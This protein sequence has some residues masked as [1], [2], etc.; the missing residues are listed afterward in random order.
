MT[1]MAEISDAQANRR[2]MMAVVSRAATNELAEPINRHWPTIAARDLKPVEIGL[3]MVRGRMGGDGQMF[4]LGET[5]MARAVIALPDGR[6]GYGHVLGRDG[7]RARLAA[8]ADALWQGEA[9]RPVI[10]REI[11]ARVSARLTHERAV[12]RSEAAA[13]KVDF[14]T[15]VRGEDA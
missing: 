12:A 2:A 5:T 15:L 13:T 7:E 11:V 9:D 1:E 10:E 6:R 14:S 4:N 8:I 3:V